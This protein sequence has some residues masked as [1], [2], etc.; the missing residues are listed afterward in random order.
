M[1]YQ[2]LC[3]EIERWINDFGSSQQSLPLCRQINQNNRMEDPPYPFRTFCRYHCNPD[4]SDTLGCSIISVSHVTL[5]KA[6]TILG[7][8][9]R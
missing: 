5:V 3:W 2:M 6:T 1:S 4:C 8:R 9:R 7:Y